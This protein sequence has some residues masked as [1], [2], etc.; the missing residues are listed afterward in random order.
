MSY[1][2]L[3]RTKPFLQK[4]PAAI[5]SSCALCG[6][7]GDQALCT[8]CE[9]RFFSHQPARC[10]QCGLPVRDQDAE[11]PC[12]ECLQARPAFDATIAA[13]DYVAPVDHLIL[14]LKFGNRLAIAPLL[15]R[16]LHDA[17]LRQPGLLLPELLT[18]VPL[19]RRRLAER[20]FNQSLEIA[21][22]LSRTTAI[23]LAAQLLE[24]TRETAVQAQ[25][26]LA[27]RHRNMRHAF[28]PVAGTEELISGRHIAV[29]DDV[30]TTGST[31]NE[32]AAVLKRHG[33]ARV[34]NLVVART[35]PK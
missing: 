18:V 35:P 11:L 6:C 23:P 4:L 14:A 7:D 9:Q 25:L 1:R 32:I 28:A 5:P 33:A 34:T 31:L 21:R 8:L 13:A 30:A 10:R 27:Q 3:S 15:A 24:R 17:L 19:G 16:L 20:G 26:P 12:A 2:F 29:V 22:P